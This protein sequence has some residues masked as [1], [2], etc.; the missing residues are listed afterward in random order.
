[1]SWLLFFSQPKGQEGA[2]SGLDNLES[3]TRNITLGVTRSTETGNEHLIVLIDE[4]ETTISWNVGSDFLVV[5]REL[6]SDALSDSGV[7]LLGLDGNL[8]NDDA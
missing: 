4:T 7:W 3:N 2:A 6:D 8:I 1:M 5:L